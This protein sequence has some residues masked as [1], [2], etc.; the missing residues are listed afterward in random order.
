MNRLCPKIE[1]INHFDNLINRVDIDIEESIGK[2]KQEQVLSQLRC[3]EVEQR[4]VKSL[5]RFS[6]KCF[7]STESENPIEYQTVDQWSESMKVIDYLNRIREKTI[8][9]L[10]KAQQDALS[11][12]KLNSSQFKSNDHHLVDEK[13]SDEMRSELFKEKFYFQVLYRPDDPKYAEPWIFKLYTFV[14]DFYMSPIDI[15]LLE[16]V[17]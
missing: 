3:F 1:I 7:D 13:N 5:K 10:T 6:L 11:H 14:S 8:N 17:F 12:Y 16:Y 2:Y 4:N 9:E 15:N